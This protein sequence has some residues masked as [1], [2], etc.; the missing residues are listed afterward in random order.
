MT[1]TIPAS[2][3]IRVFLSS[4][5]RDMEEERDY[6]LTHV[7]P[8]FRT[9]CLERLVTFTEI[10]LRWGITEDEAKNGRT[11]EVCLNEIDRCRDIRP[12]PFFIGFLGERYGWIPKSE[13]LGRYWT[14][15][16]ASPYLLRIKSA[17]EDRISV[18]ELEMRVALLEPS[19]KEDETRGRIFLR[20]RTFTDEIARKAGIAP[21]DPAFYDPADGRLTRFKEALRATSYMGLD[22]YKSLEAFG[23]AVKNFLNDELDRWFPA[24]AMP[25]HD[26]RI[27]RAHALY[28]L[29]R[30][31]AYVPLQ[32]VEDQVLTA[33]RMARIRPDSR[34]IQVTAPSGYGKSAFLA[35][36]AGR[37]TGDDDATIFVHFVGA[38]GSPELT[39]WRDRLIAFLR[40]SGPSI[41]ST[42]D[43]DEERWDSLPFLLG[44][45]AKWLGKPLVLLL[46]AIN[47]FTDA[48][49]EARA[50]AANA[51][52]T[53]ENIAAAVAAEVSRRLGTLR[54]PEG[55]VLIMSTTPDKTVPEAQPIA[56]PVLDQ[57]QRED[58]IRKFLRIHSKNFSS[59]LPTDLMPTLAS[60][61]KCEN[62][63][64][65]RLVLE[66]LRVHARYEN[67]TEK[68]RE[69]LV[70]SDAYAL[71]YHILNEMDR[72][73]ADDQ[74]SGLATQAVRLMTASW[75]GLRPSDLGSLLA[76]P[77]DPLE[78]E[79]GKPRLPDHTLAPLLA[80]LSPFCL[81]DDGRMTLMHAILRQASQKRRRRTQFDMSKLKA[82][83]EFDEERRKLILYFKDRSDSVA[84][85]EAVYQVKWLVKNIVSVEEYQNP[86]N[87]FLYED[88]Q[89][90]MQR[91]FDERG[92]LL[93][94]LLDMLRKARSFDHT[95]LLWTMTYLADLYK[96]QGSYPDQ[97][98]YLKAL[99]LYNEA[100]DIFRKYRPDDKRGLVKTIDNLA[101]IYWFQKLYDKAAALESDALDIRRKYL[102]DDS[103]GIIKA[104]NVY[105]G[106]S[107]KRG[108]STKAVRLYRE[109]LN[110]HRKALPLDNKRIAQSLINIADVF[111]GQGRYP[112]AER[113]YRKALS[114]IRESFSDG[115]GG[116]PEA[117]TKLADVCKAQGN[118]PEAVR[119][120]GERLHIMVCEAGGSR[121][122]G[123]GD[124]LDKILDSVGLYKKQG[125]DALADG[126]YRSV[127]EIL[128]NEAL[129][130]LNKEFSSEKSS[131]NYGLILPRYLNSF[132]SRVLTIFREVFP[133]NDVRMATILDSLGKLS[134]QHNRYPAAESYYREALD[135]RRKF[136]PIDQPDIAQSLDN[137]ANV[138]LSQNLYDKAEPL[139]LEILD[140]RRK[141]LSTDDPKFI[142]I[143]ERLAKLYRGWEG[144][145]MDA[146]PFY[147]EVLAILSKALPVSA[148][149]V[150]TTLNSLAGLYQAEDRKTGAEPFYRRAVEI[151]RESFPDSDPRIVDCL[152]N[153]AGLYRTLKKNDEAE[154][155]CR[156]V[157]DRV[158]NAIDS[159]D[160]DIPI[161][162]EEFYNLC[163]SLNDLASLY[164]IQ[165]RYTDAEPLYLEVLAIS[166]E[167]LSADD[168]DIADS[169][170][171][172]ANLY[173]DEGRD[174]DAEPLYREAEHIRTINA[175][176]YAD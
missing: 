167:A 73:F 165:G 34:P 161:N 80:R 88:D 104:L 72:D 106:R 137:I 91:S 126:L 46:D 19:P 14:D 24:D 13:E 159:K 120:Y 99:P 90:R 129:S 102:S 141:A 55:V 114:V 96:E 85:C 51:K 135:I 132:L 77:N 12:P 4:T 173:R 79:S 87:A 105:A 54:L 175:A 160:S 156:E 125:H 168:L 45:S 60:E 75:R 174:I 64:F 42:L 49:A 53:P 140:I 44:E 25:S 170:D 111:N 157:L 113:L 22:D 123:I 146:E 36:L 127:A 83:T 7:F 48:G 66:E 57:T 78:P 145:R 151:S 122:K 130:A 28:A 10:D 5:F 65:L 52:A 92:P 18:T 136:P 100:L 11:V 101:D 40:K 108:C 3:E 16:A 166:R 70:C 158:R 169:L 59:D 133:A 82:D 8:V 94:G 164:Q 56:L 110:I 144:R 2:R 23:E 171:R 139:L 9:L 150:I 35:H 15:H 121:Y 124:L 163:K 109:V 93:E 69:L 71:F 47:Q 62:P 107:Q 176:Y 21:G 86:G 128:Y 149:E 154:K 20:A 97:E 26:E 6:L 81:N 31:Q 162:Q 76:S 74:H 153:L 38:D 115:H 50:K 68:T 84:V 32:D 89:G 30:C 98:P 143:L 58:A 134:L 17:L 67:L 147:Q 152:R 112:A 131:V 148:Q 142:V 95:D 116:I 63:L 33:F 172:L 118:Y 155:L 119:L 39:A 61:K 117:I 37:F 138:Y 29:S 43:Q 1:L 41:S 103:Q 27:T